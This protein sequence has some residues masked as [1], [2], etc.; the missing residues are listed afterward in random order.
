MGVRI[1]MAPDLEN[2]VQRVRNGL[3]RELPMDMTTTQA[4]EFLDVSRPFVIKLTQRGDLP[5][6]LVGKHRRIPSKA[7]VAYRETMFQ[8]ARKAADEIT[9]IS[10]EA[11]LYAQ[12][13][14][15]KA[16]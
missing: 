12:E 16:Q 10:Q 3:L 15:R 9:Q 8:R 13:P 4:A 2:A 14:P 7:V 6:H 1:K 5:C 11:G